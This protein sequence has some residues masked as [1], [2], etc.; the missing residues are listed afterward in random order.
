MKMTLT[1]DDNEIL[2]EW[3]TAGHDNALANW[4]LFHALAQ[5][6]HPP[7][8]KQALE[9]EAAVMFQIY[10]RKSLAADN[11]EIGKALDATE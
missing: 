7:L 6:D 10:E 8:L 11:A 3:A 5:A 9:S 2:A 1:N 4:R